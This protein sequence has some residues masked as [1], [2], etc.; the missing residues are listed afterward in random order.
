MNLNI[1]S[2]SLCA[3]GNYWNKVELITTGKELI[4]TLTTDKDLITTDNLSRCVETYLNDSPAVPLCCC[5]VWY[6]TTCCSQP[7]CQS[8]CLFPG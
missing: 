2:I 3:I 5:I 7:T 8:N 4:R 6:G 1:L